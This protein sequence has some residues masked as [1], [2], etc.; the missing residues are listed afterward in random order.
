M[1][2]LLK[3]GFEDGTTDAWTS[4]NNVTV[5]KSPAHGVY[6]VEM[7]IDGGHNDLNFVL[8]SLTKMYVRF[9]WKP[10]NKK[11]IPDASTVRLVGAAGANFDVNIKRNVDV[12]QIQTQF[13]TGF[14][15]PFSTIRNYVDGQY[16][17]IDVWAERGAG[18]NTA[19]VKWNDVTVQTYT[20]GNTSALTN[21]HLGS[22]NGT[23]GTEV[24]MIDSVEVWD[25]DPQQD[26]NEFSAEQ[27]THDFYVTKRAALVRQD[28]LDQRPP[29][30]AA[31]RSRGRVSITTGG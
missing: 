28:R 25:D 18:A 11:D 17:V 30:L 2:L 8:A 14:P 4:T 24:M 5:V 26:F 10:P 6:A 3:D 31:R 15:T 1:T 23:W 29:G 19:F 27:A 21:L 13:F 7:P 20:P 16:Q 9:W 22:L 12:M